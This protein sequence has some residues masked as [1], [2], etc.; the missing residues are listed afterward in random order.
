MPASHD[1][2]KLKDFIQYIEEGRV[3]L[4]NFQ[5][6]FVWSVEQQK[7]MLSSFVVEL[8]VGSLLILNGE[9]GDFA[10]RKLCYRGA[11][12]RI[13][14]ECR[15]LLD[16]Q[17][18]TSTLSSIFNN[19]F[20]SKDW[21]SDTVDMFPNLMNRWCL[22]LEPKAEE[23]DVFGYDKLNFRALDLHNYEPNDVREFI[24]SFKIFKTK[25]LDQWYHPAVNPLDKTT[26]KELED[27]RKS[28]WIA[29]QAANSNLVPLWE[30]F[31]KPDDGI[32]VQ[33][34]KKIGDA[35][36]DKIKAKVNDQEKGYAIFDVLGH[37]DSEIEN[38]VKNGDTA[39]VLS[40]WSD[41]KARW[42]TQVHEAL[43]KI[44]EQS[45][46][47][48]VLP[49]NEVSRAIAC[50]SSVN[51]GGTHLDTFDLI[52]AKAARQKDLETL[53]DRIITAVR[54]EVAIPGAITKHLIG[55]K[56]NSW[57]P[58]NFGAL[59]DGVLTPTFKNLYLNLMSLIT[60][61]KYESNPH[62]VDHIKSKSHLSLTHEQINQYSVNCVRALLRAFSFL[63][64]RC[65]V[66][67]LSDVSFTLMVLPLAY[68][69]YEESSFKNSKK[70]DYLEY[71]YWLS[72][73]SG[74]YRVYPNDVCIND[75][76]KLSSGINKG[77]DRYKS[78]ES[79]VLNAEDYSNKDVLLKKSDVDIQ[80]SIHRTILQYV[81]SKQPRDFIYDLNMNAWDINRN[82]EII[83][84]N[85][86]VNLKMALNDHH[87]IPLATAT[88]MT[89]T[90]DKLRADKNHI[91]N[92]PLNRT[93]I[94]EVSNNN[95]GPKN[96]ADYMKYVCDA[97]SW[98]HCLP[99]ESQMTK[100][101]KEDDSAYYERV[102]TARY[103]KIRQDVT[104]ELLA[105]KAA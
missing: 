45:V 92:S 101:D 56:P 29:S 51:E 27:H 26:Q 47:L 37:I 99:I 17:Q 69:F 81:L 1:T 97:S 31:S 20:T 24:V 32:H 89:E 98:N 14:E 105:L 58:S 78:E 48:I 5:R 49:A 19:Y 9:R 44:L 61:C 52:V 75:V 59:K 7:D 36:V 10:S 71:W 39:G 95:I 93:Y 86:K 55:T 4:P 72:L 100:N 104:T 6:D 74:R 64:I 18:R 8:P 57:S 43:K 83:D 76:S 33:A 42:Q 28:E 35:V 73:F 90:S 70:V 91:L 85:R 84:G 66:V 21:R 11:P 54:E 16:G 30:L 38:K 46:P 63:N 87:I 25:K 13:K 34:L 68:L 82:F 65:G 15:Y 22:R 2:I 102:L 23:H 80:G 62:K 94:L 103:E 67:K 88:N 41:L 96:V 3:V 40:A 12:D 79:K 50:F 60:F 77:F 53:T